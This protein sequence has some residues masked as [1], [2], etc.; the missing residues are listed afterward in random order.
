MTF[1]KI[2]CPGGETSQTGVAVALRYPGLS[3]ESC[4]DDIAAIPE[5]IKAIPGDYAIPIWNSHVG[6]IGPSRFVWDG[7][8]KGSL[9]LSDIW[10]KRIEFW[11]V[12]LKGAGIRYK[13][14]GSV[15]VAQI[16]CS[17]FLLKNEFELDGHGLTTVAF[18]E[19][20]KGAPW[21][22]VFLADGQGEGEANF[23][24]IERRVANPN[25]FTSFV[26]ATSTSVDRVSDDPD[27]VKGSRLTG[28]A[29]QKFGASLGDAEQSLFNRIF[30]RAKNLND[31]PRLAFVFARE[32]KVGLLFEGVPLYRADLLDAEEIESADIKIFEDVGAMQSLYSEQLRQLFSTEFPSLLED[33]FILH[34]GVHTCLFACP[35]LGLFTHGFL[36][37]SVEPVIRFYIGRLFEQWINGL[38]CSEQQDKFFEKYYSEWETHG[39]AFIKFKKIA[40]T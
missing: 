6:E 9:K 1:E 36:K 12:R 15:R 19:Y 39:S 38:A 27:G 31:V 35:P 3:I 10:A 32:S 4:G 5:L 23:E 20:K 11:W 26:T 25:N 34:E 22:G 13:K 14:I 40:A 21:D 16:Q 28:I 2:Y 7:I 30:E 8:E 37:E 33:D 24:V 29:I 17:G 18:E